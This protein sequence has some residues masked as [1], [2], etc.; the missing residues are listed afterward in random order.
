M[1]PDFSDHLHLDHH[2][3]SGLFKS[4]VALYTGITAAI[5]TVFLLAQPSLPRSLHF[6]PVVDQFTSSPSQ[7]LFG[8]FQPVHKNVAVASMFPFHEDVYLTIVQQMEDLLAPYDGRVQVYSPTPLPYGFQDIVDDLELYSGSFKAPKDF[9]PALQS[10]QFDKPIDLVLLGTCNFDFRDW[11]KEMIAIWDSRPADQKFQVACVAHN[12]NDMHYWSDDF[13]A[14]SERGVLRIIAIADHVAH[15]FHEF[16]QDLADEPELI[17]SGFEYIKTDVHV[18]VLDLPPRTRTPSQVLSQ[19]VVQGFFSPER[20]DYARLFQELTQAI[21]EDPAVWGYQALNATSEKVFKPIP[22]SSVPPFQLNLAGEGYLEVPHVLRNV[23]KKHAG[24]SY[25][26]FYDL[27]E[28]MDVVIPAFATNIYYEKQ[29]SSTV[30]MAIE[31]DVPMLVTHRFRESYTYADDD[32]VL[33]T[34]PQGLSEIG[35]LKVFRTQ[36]YIPTPGDLPEFVHDVHE[37]L[38]G[39]WKRPV[40]GFQAMKKEL[41]KRN[42]DVARRILTDQ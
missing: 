5:L 28:S 37:M 6:K 8:D 4:R 15:A 32:R 30:V 34:R 12:L 29:A 17:A 16:F 21:L 42:K 38:D 33:I 41:W 31:C 36:Q 3:I 40:E 24:L 10:T 7:Y 35:A 26:E 23:V 9:L 20:R 19:A 2:S 39:G 25:P 22:D 18:P 13:T 27:M 14:L 11:G 1:P